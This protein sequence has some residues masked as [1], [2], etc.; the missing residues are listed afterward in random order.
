MNNLSKMACT[1]VALVFT[2]YFPGTEA[3]AAVLSAA[4]TFGSSQSVDTA[5]DGVSAVAQAEHT[6]V[7]ANGGNLLYGRS[8]A[9]ASS[10]HAENIGAG[11]G[12]IVHPRFQSSASI[13]VS[14]LIFLTASGSSDPFMVTLNANLTGTFGLA[15]PPANNVNALGGA[16]IR[17]RIGSGALYDEYGRTI[18]NGRVVSKQLESRRDGIGTESTMLSLSFSVLPGKARSI[19]V[20]LMTEANGGQ[21]W[22]ETYGAAAN[23]YES[24]HLDPTHVFD[25]PDGVTVSSASWG[26]VENQLPYAINGGTTTVPVPAGLP[27]L[28]A[29]VGMLSLLRYQKHRGC[30]A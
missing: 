7:W 3:K 23:A 16:F 12:A 6:Q 8:K 20:D 2:G 18:E 5:T 10:L 13:R 19:W 28:L 24:L 26:L 27:L 30:R 17:G 1:A 29:G 21:V 25:L 11:P 4:V 22:Y 15:Q 9:T 14:D